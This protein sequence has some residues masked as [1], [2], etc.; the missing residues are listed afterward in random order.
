MAKRTYQAINE[1]IDGLKLEEFDEAIYQLAEPFSSDN[2]YSVGRFVIKDNAIYQKITSP[3]VK[4]KIIQPYKEQ[5]LTGNEIVRNGITWTVHNDGSV[6]ATGTASS[7]SEFICNDD[8]QLLTNTYYTLSGCSNGSS[9]T[10][11]IYIDSNKIDVGNGV[12]FLNDSSNNISVTIKILSGVQV[13]SQM[14]YPQIEQGE[15]KTSYQRP[16]KSNESWID[17]HWRFIKNI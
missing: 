15:T 2:V 6:S 10:F 9:S 8:L 1:T 11:Y 14:F 17:S 12:T 7:D 13:T 4:N 16:N 5:L 3:I